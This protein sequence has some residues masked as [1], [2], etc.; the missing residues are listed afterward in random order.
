MTISIQDFFKNTTIEKLSGT[1]KETNFNRIP[2]VEIQ[3]AYPITPSQHRIWIVS[4]L[5][6]GSVAYNLARVIKLNG[7]LDFVKFQKSFSLLLDRHESLRTYFKTN[8]N[9]EVC[10]FIKP[11]GE[12]S[13][14]IVQYDFSNKE[15]D[16][17]DDYLISFLI[18][19]IISDGW[20]IEI[21]ISEIV[22]N[23]NNLCR[24]IEIK[25]PELRIQYKDYTVWKVRQKASKEYKKAEAFWLSKLQGDLPVL[26]LPSFKNRPK[27]W[28]FK[29]STISHKY[30]ASFLKKLKN[31][32]KEKDVD[33][34]NQIGMYLNMLAIRTLVSNDSFVDLLQKQKRVLLEAFDHQNYPLDDLIA[35]LNIKR[36]ISRSPLFDVLV[37]LQ[38]Q[39]QIK[40]IQSSFEL[41]GID[42]SP[43]EVM[44]NTAKFDL[45]FHFIESDKLELSI[46]YNKDIYDEFLIS[47][48]FDHLGNLIEEAIKYPKEKVA[49]LCY[50]SKNEKKNIL[51]ATGEISSC[52]T[53]NTI[54]EFFE[55][56]VINNP[57]SIALV[58]DNRQ[59]SY[60]QFNEL[61]NK[62]AHYLIAEHGVGPGELIGI[63]LERNEWIIISILAVLKI[64]IRDNRVS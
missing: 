2:R 36:D 59:L 8:I 32:S 61:A 23:Y 53:N 7:D 57:D 31:F 64:Y 20:S 63:K 22:E 35:K 18:H 58:F 44:D 21:L 15:K 30:S 29:G 9:G 16:E 11:V 49:S 25:H 45:T 5:E 56:Q 50:I 3:D 47:R 1:I 40:T 12:V 51:K 6:G 13:F 33:T 42:S 14:E 60:S 62:L 37:V 28:N 41:E 54:V 46:Q 38:N 39:A 26:K 55:S 34:Q 19:H 43:Y 27:L 48:I 4:Q 17:I 10:Q 24:Q 52:L